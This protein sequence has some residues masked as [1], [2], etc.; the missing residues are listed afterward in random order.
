MTVTA[1]AVT[2][3]FDGRLLDVE[4]CIAATL[5]QRL[6]RDVSRPYA[7]KSCADATRL[8]ETF[9]ADC[10]PGARVDAVKRL[11][12]GSSKEQFVFSL[13][14]A[15]GPARRYVLRM[16]PSLSAVE[17]DRRREF[18]MIRAMDGTVPVAPAAWLDADGSR[19]GQPSAIFGFVG[20]VT[21]PSDFDAAHSTIMGPSFG[22]RLRGRVADQYVATMAALHSFDW[23]R[24][25]LPS[26]AA[27]LAD[28]QQAARWQLNWWTR[29][30]RDDDMIHLPLR[31]AAE[32]WM[33]A[34]LPACTEPVVVH[35]D[36]RPGNYLFDDET[37]AFTALLDW[38]LCHIGDFHEDL[39]MIMSRVFGAT[40]ADGAFRCGGLLTRDELVDRYQ[41]TTG[42]TVDPRTLLFYEIL[43]CYKCAA[44]CGAAAPR[45]V[46]TMQNHQEVQQTIIAMATPIFMA[47]IAALLERAGSL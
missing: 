2:A 23:R 4:P 38:E 18:E 1:Q 28:P 45:T 39:G 5:D 20:G 21:R 24:A 30:W 36:Y 3:T 13:I 35:A 7:I 42:R 27:P 25:D 16:D 19:F 17:T 6:A 43:S 11:G 26:F 9:F 12:G 8:L 31:A 37:G 44:I 47:E 32:A 14:P 40:D 29:V 33:R 34:N 15:D 22:D 10:M 41:R 46:Q